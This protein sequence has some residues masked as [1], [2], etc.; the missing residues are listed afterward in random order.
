MARRNNPSRYAQRMYETQLDKEIREREVRQRGTKSPNEIMQQYRRIA[1]NSDGLRTARAKEIMQRYIGNI[2]GPN[3][4]GQG[5]EGAMNLLRNGGNM[6]VP[7]SV[8]M[9][10]SAKG[11]G[12]NGLSPYN[13]Y[14][15]GGIRAFAPSS[16]VKGLSTA[17]KA[18]GGAG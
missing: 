1:Q 14:E 11:A 15:H 13:G 4:W 3:G 7:R 8:Y 10:T 18:A 16:V 6:R 5:A 17:S 12:G 2:A 9:G